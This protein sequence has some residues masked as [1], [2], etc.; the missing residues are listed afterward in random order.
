MSS[1]FALQSFAHIKL[2]QRCI[3]ASNKSSYYHDLLR[4]HNLSQSTASDTPSTMSSNIT[5]S[6]LSTLRLLKLQAKLLPTDNNN[7]PSSTWNVS[8]HHFSL[9]L[10]FVVDFVIDHWCWSTSKHKVGVVSSSLSLDKPKRTLVKLVF[11]FLCSI[12][13]ERTNEQEQYL[14]NIPLNLSC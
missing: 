10:L 5:P 7:S 2:M 11:T 12:S 1:S 9:L 8:P 3:I 6:I 4:E 14:Q 13:T